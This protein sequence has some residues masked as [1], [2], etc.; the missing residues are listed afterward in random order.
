[1]IADHRREPGDDADDDL[2]QD[3]AGD[4]EDDEHD[5]AGDPR[6]G[7]ACTRLGGRTPRVRPRPAALPR[8]ISRSCAS[9]SSKRSDAAA[10]LHSLH[11]GE[12]V[13]S[14]P[15]DRSTAEAAGSLSARSR[16]REA[17]AEEVIGGHGAL[18]RRRA[19]TCRLSKDRRAGFDR[20]SSG[21]HASVYERNAAAPPRRPRDEATCRSTP[22]ARRAP[23]RS[24]S[25][26]STDG[27]SSS[28]GRRRT[29]RRSGRRPG[30]P[31]RATRPGA[32]VPSQRS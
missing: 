17:A 1:M 25:P 14:G 11:A 19:P 20:L 16:M 18:G 4:Q 24:S 9:R 23:R 26:R 28:H 7:R 22:R 5:H 10:R 13:A 27:R 31:G 32:P 30:C 15:S 29:R 21:R 6:D 3:P 12:A 8:N 2:E